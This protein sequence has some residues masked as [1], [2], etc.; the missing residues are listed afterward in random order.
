MARFRTPVAL[1]ALAF[2]LAATSGVAGAQVTDTAVQAT[3]TTTETE[4]D[5]GFDAGLLGLLGLAGLLG[6]RKNRDEVVVTRDTTTT[7]V[8]GAPRRP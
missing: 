4:D 6:L 2:A 8:G 3:G 7:G 5:G 1:T